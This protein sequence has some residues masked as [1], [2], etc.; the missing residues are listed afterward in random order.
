MLV[1]APISYA[2]F[3]VVFPN[4][5]IKCVRQILFSFSIQGTI[6]LWII[7]DEFSVSATDGVE[8][9][10]TNYVYPFSLLQRFYFSSGVF[11]HG[12]IKCTRHGWGREQT[13]AYCISAQCL[14]GILFLSRVFSH[15]LIK[16]IRHG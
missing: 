2:I 12:L 8:K 3:T 6:S 1:S 11:S 14:P 9:R 15:G 16:C 4:G 10:Q 5:L 13:D 7:Y